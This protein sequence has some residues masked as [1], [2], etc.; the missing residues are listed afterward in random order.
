MPRVYNVYQAF[1]WIALVVFAT[2]AMLTTAATPAAA[3]WYADLYGGGSFTK[4]TNDTQDSSLGVTFTALNVK[5]DPS[6]AVGGRVGYW[7]DGLDWLGMGIDMFYFRPKAPDQSVTV[8]VS[9]FGN[10]R[11]SD[12]FSLPVFG[13][14][15]DVVRLRLPLLRSEEFPHGQLQPYL[16]AGPAYS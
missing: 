5:V 4:N 14:G 2:V 9:G 1:M 12:H 10:V 15:F 6:F 7:F 16:T 13:I 8:S 3:E 11:G